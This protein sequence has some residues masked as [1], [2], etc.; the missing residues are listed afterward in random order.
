[1][2]GALKVGMDIL[3]KKE[4]VAIDKIYGHGG[5][6][7]TKGVGQKLLAAAIDTPV[8]VMETA[9]EGGPWGMALLASYLT[10]KGEDET[11]QNYLEGKVFAGNAGTS[12]EPVQR[13]SKVLRSLLR[14]IKVQ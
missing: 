8:S 1:M 7:T 12:E 13:I 10:W 6:F 2:P 3:I 9:G 14:I 11:L 4:H 5:Y